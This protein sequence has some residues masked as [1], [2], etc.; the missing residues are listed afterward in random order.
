MKK[1]FLFI[2]FIS[3]AAQSMDKKPEKQTSFTRLSFCS[4]C[5]SCCSKKVSS[6]KAALAH[7]ASSTAVDQKTQAETN[8]SS[9]SNTRY[10]HIRFF[11]TQRLIPTIKKELKSSQYNKS[12]VIAG[13]KQAE[14]AEK[15]I[16]TL[17]Q[18]KEAKFILDEAELLAQHLNKTEL[19]PGKAK[20]EDSK[21]IF[22]KLGTLLKSQ[23][24]FSKLCS[25]D[26]EYQKVIAELEA[27]EKA[28]QVYNKKE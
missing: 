23:V 20:P 4:S 2:L 17:A 15:H 18:S 7:A 5:W 10:P 12:Y 26:P 27:M 9:S 8:V 11:F 3:N 6:S 24:L 21:P 13:L 28:G 16:D 1:I 25:L 22:D 19:E 14:I